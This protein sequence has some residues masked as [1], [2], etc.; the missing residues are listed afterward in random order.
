MEQIEAK[1][2]GRDYTLAVEP[3]DRQRVLDAVALV[4]QKMSAIRDAGRVAGV[5]RIAVMAALQ[6]AH[7]LLSKLGPAGA[8][9]RV[10]DGETLRRVR[11]LSMDIDA[12]LQR[13]ATL[14]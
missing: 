4:D 9:G 2:L 7:E 3:D 6:L 8:E 14:F 5:D 13:Q 12:E 11:K 10:A 1:I